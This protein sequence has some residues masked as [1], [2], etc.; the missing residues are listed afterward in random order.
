MTI[1]L[2]GTLLCVPL[3]GFHPPHTHISPPKYL[4]FQ[5]KR[6]IGEQITQP[7]YHSLDCNHFETQ[8]T[9]TEH[10]LISKISMF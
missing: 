7:I 3:N 2:P 9:G 10:A 4:V 8:N 1:T 5:A 6:E